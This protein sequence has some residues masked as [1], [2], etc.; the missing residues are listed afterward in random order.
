MKVS[1]NWLRDYV[2]FDGTPAALAELLTMAGVEVEGVE[3]RGVNIDKVVV[4]QILASE[5]H[6]DADRLSVCRVDDGSGAQTL[7]QIVC[8]AKNYRVG[9][10]VPLA[11]PGATLPGNFQIKVGKLRGVQS[12]GMMCSAKELGLSG[13]AAGLLILSPDARVGAP[14]GEMFPGDTVFDLEITPNRPDLL[15]HI[16]LARE[17]A[18]LTGKSLRWPAAA[19]WR[20]LATE[21]RDADAEF[22]VALAAD[23]EAACPFYSA[24]LLK[25]VNVG[26]SPDW[27]RNRL[28]SV[29]LRSINNVVDVT[30]YV[31]L[32]RGQPLHAFDAQKIPSGG[33]EP[34]MARPG[35]EFLALDGKPYKLAAHHLVIAEKNGGKALA[36]AGV[37]GGADSGVTTQT[38]DIVLESAYFAPAGI[39]RASRELGLSSDSS[40]RFE[41]GVDPGAVAD[42]SLRAAQ[43]VL[44]VAGGEA[45][46]LYVAQTPGFEEQA[47]GGQ[48][49]MLRPTRCRR[50]LGVDVPSARTHEILSGF[51]LRPVPDNDALWQIPSYRGDLTREVDLIEEVSR[52]VGLDQ[53]PGRTR[54]FF[55]PVS[56]V[57]H[58]FDFQMALRRKLAGLGFAEARS[59]S[60]ISETAAK[61]SGGVR[62]KNPLSEEHAILRGSLLP[63]LLE[64]AGRNA[65]LG[66]ADL[67][68]FELGR[69][70]SVEAP[71]GKPEPTRLAILVS[72]AAMPRSWRNAAG[73]T[74]DFHDLRGIIESLAP[75]A[76]VDF[77]AIEN[78]GDHLALA[79]EILLDGEVIGRAGQLNPA[80]AKEFDLRAPTLTAEL[81]TAAL[82]KLS[83]AGRR[84]SALARFPSVTRDLALV[85]DDAAPHGRIVGA[86]RGAGEAL[87]SDVEL[88]DVFTDERGEKIPVGKKSLAYSL[89]YRA[90][91]RTLKTEEVNAAHARLKKALQSAFDG[92]QFR[93]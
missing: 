85:V 65:R 56:E 91:D 25:G 52:V 4:A 88:F 14:I 57:D 18:A 43:L 27:L 81:E 34:R 67:R 55:A 72:G 23:A 19:E 44:Q 62:L 63:G 40:Y 87:L 51:G 78:P 35:E 5:P 26:P 36:L 20:K 28:E 37:M 12:E 54:G 1:L 9:D 6:P 59:L 10:K 48:L 2:D 61:D 46:G 41:R 22:S 92:L 74:L 89:T 93:E 79:A 29:G 24:R 38:R 47:A 30:N 31:L 70:F 8:G 68:L 83:L 13:D 75:G 21:P 42:A 17:I 73:R 64:A 3:T 58:A 80:R 15:S 45:R 7:R 77:K 49:V 86:L 32:E 90:E 60:L 39:R 33:L 50:L 69:V 53:T 76:K 66:T 84:F 16:G 71:A 11:L 82:Q